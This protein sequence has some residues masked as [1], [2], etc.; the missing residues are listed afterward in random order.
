MP[1]RLISP[2][3]TKTYDLRD[4]VPLIVGRAPTCDLPVF[5]PTIS[6][7]HAELTSDGTILSLR[8]LGS[9]NGTF[10][11]GAKIERGHATIDDL[12]AFGKVGFRLEAVASATPAT[13]NAVVPRTTVG[14]TIVRQIP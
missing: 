7:R 10:V 11:N 14:A 8:D 9:S 13:A 3:G 2:D 12:L 1:L 5:H 6:R 4:G